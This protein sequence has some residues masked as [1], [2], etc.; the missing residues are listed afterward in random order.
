MA[1][2]I[3]F[4]KK[5]SSANVDDKPISLQD[6]ID[7]RIKAILVEA[8][9]LADI[10]I[11]HLGEQLDEAEIAEVSNEYF[12]DLHHVGEAI[13]SL[14]YRHKKIPHPFHEMVDNMIELR[15]DNGAVIATWNEEAF[16]NEDE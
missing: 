6:K 2:I 16:E 15:Y 7:E 8:D 13:R 4:P 1:D 3:Q 9:E 5:E 11:D 12:R 14:I 10:W